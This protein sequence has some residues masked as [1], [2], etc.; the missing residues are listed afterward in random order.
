MCVASLQRFAVCELAAPVRQPNNASKAR[1]WDNPILA[2]N[3]NE[4]NRGWIK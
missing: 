2:R 4:T 3:H 1:L